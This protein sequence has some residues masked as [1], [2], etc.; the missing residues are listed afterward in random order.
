MKEQ[1]QH[2][3][4]S[5]GEALKK[6]EDRDSLEVVRTTF[7]GRKGA[8]AELMKEM[9]NLPPEEKKE[10]GK[11]ANQTKREMEKAFE[12]KETIFDVQ[13]RKERVEQEW[14]DVT[15]P[16]IQKKAQGSL[17][18]VTQVQND[19]EDLFTSMGFIIADGPELESDYFNFTTLNIPPTHP[20][21]D[22][23]DTFYLEG[24]G[25]IVM[26]THTSPV[27]IRTMREYGAPLRMI[28]PGRCFRNEATDVRHEHTF[29]QLEGMVIDKGIT[30]G[31]MKGVLE[32]VAKRLYGPETKMRLR[33]K[34][35]PFVEPGVN[36][37]VTCFL[38][39]GKGCRLCKK[40]GWLEIFGAGMVHPNVLKE[41]GI[42]PEV[43]TGFAFG[44]GLTRLVMLKYG[45][46][47]VRLLES[48]DLRFLKQFSVC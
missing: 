32:I 41:G 6:V 37:E 1:F 17:H 20:A 21:R 18:P 29:H 4:E 43:Y 35:Y 27:Q 48:G 15:Q 33:P 13:E 40:T 3:Q 31:H 14:I 8:L 46:D 38:C 28:A 39:K 45:I 16:V 22:M 9:S 2:I 19:L 7:L 24:R 34:F 25:D 12:E 47:D 36:G 30:F 42:N 5:L 26:R 23:H 10:T 11:V 44:F